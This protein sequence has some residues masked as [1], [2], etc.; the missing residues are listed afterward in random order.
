MSKAQP[1]GDPNACDW[2][3]REMSA[4]A[5]DVSALAHEMPNVSR[6]PK[7]LARGS[8]PARFGMPNARRRRAG[9]RKLPERATFGISRASFGTSGASARMGWATRRAPGF[10]RL[11]RARRI[12]VFRA[13]RR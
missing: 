5:P 7:F 6:Y 2:I 10:S 3:G 8:A 13:E 11:S 4:V 1:Y 12:L 9:A